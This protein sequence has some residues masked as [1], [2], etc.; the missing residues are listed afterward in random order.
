MT[1]GRQWAWK[2][3]E[4]IKSL[5]QCLQ[6]L[7]RSAG[8]DGNLLF[9]VGPRPDGTIEPMQVMRLKEMGEW[10][11]KYGYTIYGT[12]GGPL[13]P[14][15]WGVSTRKGNKIFLHILKWYGGA[16]RISI[17][18]LGMGIKKCIL[19]DGGEVTLNKDDRGYEISFDGSHLKPVNTIVEIEVDGKAMDI[20]PQDAVPQSLSYMKKV[21][22]STN[23]NPAWNDISSVNN[24]DWAGLFWQ[25]AKDDKLP[26]VEIDLGMPSVI[27]RAVLYES[28]QKI[29]TFELQHRSDEKWITFYRGIPADQITDIKFNGIKSQNIRLIITSC[30]GTPGI[31]EFLLLSE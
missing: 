14:S 20:I 13:K 2:P 16:V 21:T 9:N 18:D 7:I 17:P 25:P 28:G 27:S 8:G 12:R 11:S 23:P 6:S 31:Y 30:T 1:I 3:N 15:D 10:L 22:S 24:G 26:W 19:A 29:K 4:E 5:E